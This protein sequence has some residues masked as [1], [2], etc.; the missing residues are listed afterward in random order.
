MESLTRPEFIHEITIKHKMRFA[1]V[2]V[3][4]TALFKSMEKEFAGHLEKSPQTRQLDAVRSYGL[5]FA[6]EADQKTSL[7]HETGDRYYKKDDILIAYC[8]EMQAVCLYQ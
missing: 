4:D 1:F 5:E 7:R 2:F 3:S 8:E 6:T